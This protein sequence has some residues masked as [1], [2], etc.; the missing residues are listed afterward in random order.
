VSRQRAAVAAVR[1][2]RANVLLLGVVQLCGGVPSAAA[3]E[4][5]ALDAVM[6][7][8]DA[9]CQRGAFS[10]AVDQLEALSDRGV[11][12]P[13]VSFDRG[14]V[15]L[16][17]AESPNKQRTD[18][19]QA[20]A[21]FQEA[22][23]LDPSD[24]EAATLLE[25]VREQISERRASRSNDPM[26]ARPR[27]VRAVLGLIGENIWALLALLGSIALTAGLALRLW[28]HNRNARLSGSV[29]SAIGLVLLVL[30]GGMAAAARQLRLST[31]PAVVIAEQ[32][33]LLDAA[34]RPVSSASHRE[35]GNVIP[36]GSAVY[37]KETKGALAFVEWGELDAW[38]NL[39][40][41]RRLASR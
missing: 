28:A 12:H 2:L 39:R 30:G 34:G 37:V 32:A 17:R 9:A 19:G 8:V 16:R 18:L 14:L 22:S 40:E 33:Q 13:A 21:A 38:V 7:Q 27:L 41:L 35:V 25:R 29:V 11:V 20:A 23:E 26:M 15:Y 31:S 24:E 10:E 3:D 6:A 5:P 36:E 1:L 4:P